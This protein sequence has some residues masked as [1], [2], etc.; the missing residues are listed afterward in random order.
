VAR[1]NI[2]AK[3]LAV[4]FAVVYGGLVGG[5]AYT[6][7]YYEGPGQPSDRASGSVPEGAIGVCRVPNSKR[8]PIVSDKL[9]EDT[10]I[11]TTKTPERFIRLGYGPG[12]AGAATEAD[13]DKNM[14]RL[15]AVL[16]EGQ[17]E[18]TGNNQLVSTLRA[19]HDY[20]LKDPELRDRVSRESS[21]P[22]VCDY[23]YLLNTMARERGKLE[24]SNRCAAQAYDP[25][26]RGE[27]CLF[28]TTRDE[29]VW[30]TSSWS[31]ATHSGEIGEKTSC[32]QLCAYDD[33]CAKQVSCAAPDID[34]LL[35]AMGVCIPEPKAGIR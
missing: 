7:F 10:R 17:K 30:L 11:C 35:C 32:F 16:R 19:L 31:C 3:G 27:S 8:P 20:G 14:E 13:A 24:Q 29:V 18:D 5:C 2:A 28:D 12:L 21:R 23:T 33:Y 26:S 1:K 22:S 4:A 6:E 15:L 34:L 9:W 25:K